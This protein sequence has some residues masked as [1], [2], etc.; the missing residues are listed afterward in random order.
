MRDTVLDR[1]KLFLHP[2]IS[3]EKM[4]NKNLEAVYLDNT[5]QNGQVT[6]RYGIS[7]GNCLN[8]RIIAI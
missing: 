7:F 4:Q 2:L 8:I 5:E 3:S 1:Y 6:N